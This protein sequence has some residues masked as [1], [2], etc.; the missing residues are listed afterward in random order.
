[1][2]VVLS[3]AGKLRLEDACGYQHR[4]RESAENVQDFHC[5]PE[6][7]QGEEDR[8]PLSDKIEH[9]RSQSFSSAL[10]AS[11][12]PHILKYN[13]QILI[14]EIFLIIQMTQQTPFLKQNNSDLSKISNSQK[15]TNRREDRRILAWRQTNVI[16]PRTEAVAKG[17]GRE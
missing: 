17:G 14:K 6:R 2:S 11:H 1:M 16:S 13:S 9:P 5:T 12:L 4:R 7:L 10:N 8:T 15:G 3:V